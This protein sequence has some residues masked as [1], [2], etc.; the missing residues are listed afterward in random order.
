MTRIENLTDCL[1]YLR[2]NPAPVRTDMQVAA[3]MVACY[4][5][6]RDGVTIAEA[7]TAKPERPVKLYRER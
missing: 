6:R 4:E 1:K 7:M 2:D 5:A 3:L